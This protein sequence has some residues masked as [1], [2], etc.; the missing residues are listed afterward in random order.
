MRPPKKPGWLILAGALMLGGC[1]ASMR[2]STNINLSASSDQTVQTTKVS[3]YG[4]KA[5]ALNLVAI[6]DILGSYMD[7]QDDVTVTY[8]GVKGTPYWDALEL[9][10]KSGHLDDVFMIDHDRVL[11]MSEAGD[12]A[13]LSNLASLESFDERIRHQLVNADGN[14]YFLPLCVTS[15]G[16]YINTD[17]LEERGLAIPETWSEFLEVCQAFKADGITPV[18]GNKNYSLKVLI[19]AAS[20]YDTY[21]AD[22]SEQR[23]AAFNAD[24]EL[25]ARTLQTGL[26]RVETLLNA[27]YVDTK[28]I[29]TAA[30]TSDDLALFLEGRNP[31]MVTGSWAKVR[32]DAMDP[33]FDYTIK[34]Y[35]VREEGSVLVVDVSTCI[36]VNQNSEHLSEALELANY[37]MEEDILW[38]Y[39]DSQAS[40]SPIQNAEPPT[41]A[42]IVEL[43]EPYQNNEAVF[44]A[45]YT[46]NY[47]MNSILNEVIQDL[48]EGRGAKQAGDTLLGLLQE[49]AG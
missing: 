48:L 31:F 12:L 9:R 5:D 30:A 10:W 38:K 47:P 46:L 39:A 37:M 42:E 7:S 19:L 40:F 13:D 35:P 41:D 49:A 14:V 23:V 2:T 1:S 32:F 20:L 16:L 45:D 43:Y 6:E 27:G 21:A 34:A 3:F 28:Q 4:Y 26:D 22:N 24:P 29:S 25:F 18:I 17:L 44:G 36:A 15:Y 11:M 33:D 8:E